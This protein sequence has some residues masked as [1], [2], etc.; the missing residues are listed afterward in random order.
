[1]GQLSFFHNARYARALRDTRASAV[2]L[3]PDH[4]GKCATNALLSDRPYLCFARATHLFERR[5]GAAAGVHPSAVV[6]A[7]AQVHPSASIGPFVVLGDNVRIGARVRIGAHCSVGDDSE[8]GEDSVL[9]AGVHIYHGVR[10]GAR[11][12]LH[13]GVVIG[14]DGFGFA[15]DGGRHQKIAQLGGVRIGDDVEIG[16]G[17]CVDRGA[18]DDTVIGNGVKIDNQ[19]QIAHNVLI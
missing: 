18:L 2:I 7:S 12:I 19:V 11:A 9:H 3:H 8:V 16:A 10:V 13:S 15:P 14:A 6:P 5:S 17:S 1:P 4:L